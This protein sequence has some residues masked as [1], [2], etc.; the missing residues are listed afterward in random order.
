MEHDQHDFRRMVEAERCV[1]PGENSTLLIG[2]K[3]VDEKRT[4]EDETRK[5]LFDRDKTAVDY[6]VR[7]KRK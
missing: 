2:F 5:S 6:L 4:S 7:E 3:V 1:A